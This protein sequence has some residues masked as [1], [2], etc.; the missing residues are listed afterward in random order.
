MIMASGGGRAA[1]AIGPDSAICADCL[2]E[3]LAP[4]DRRYRYA[5]INCTHCGPRYTITRQLPYDRAMTSMAAFAQCPACLA[6]YRSPVDRRFHAEPNA[7]PACGPRLSVRGR[8]RRHRRG[9][10]SR[11][12]D[13]RAAPA[14][15]DRRDQGA[16]RIPPRVRRAQCRR[17]CAPAAA[18]VARGEAAR[19]HGG[20]RRV[21][22]IRSRSCPRRSTRRSRPS[23]GP[24]CCCASARA[25]TPC[26]RTSR[27]TWRGSA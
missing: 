7:C 2:R 18:Q 5:F 1:T 20:E 27:P 11:R 23:S 16:G 6:E 13:R 8:G 24:S 10:R 15:R 3:L 12:R 22:A 26:C 4:A 19:R 25:W 17:R 14:R 21:G 9:G